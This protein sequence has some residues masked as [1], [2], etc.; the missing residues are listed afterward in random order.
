[1]SLSIFSYLKSYIL[2]EKRN[3]QEDY[4]TQLFAWILENIPGTATSYVRF[5][6]DK[7]S[8][9]NIPISDDTL[10]KVDTQRVVS[11]G[12]IDMFLSVDDKWGI[13][14]EHKIDSELSENQIEKYKLYP[15]SRTF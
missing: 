4:L 7:N 10:I 13:I 15:L 14:C 1:M 9:I 6:C 5:L 11:S 8:N 3:P 12:R 2:T